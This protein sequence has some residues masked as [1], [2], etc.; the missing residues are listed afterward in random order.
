[1][2]ATAM[3]Q[4]AT[5]VT[6]VTM[7]ARMTAIPDCSQQQERKQLQEY[8]HQELKSFHENLPKNPQNGEK[9]VKKTVKK[10]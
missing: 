5:T 2:Q 1:M 6:P 10:S 4:A 7:T 9:F 3:A 8:R